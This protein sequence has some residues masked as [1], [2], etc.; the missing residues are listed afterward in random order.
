MALQANANIRSEQGI[1][2]FLTE[3]VVDRVVA[4]SLVVEADA[5]GSATEAT[6]A[7]QVNLLSRSLLW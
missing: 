5:A 1:D 6:E 3:I 2:L 4:E 7:T